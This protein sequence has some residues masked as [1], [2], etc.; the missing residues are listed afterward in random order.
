MGDDKLEIPENITMKEPNKDE[1]L[2]VIDILEN[3]EFSYTFKYCS[4]KKNC[5]YYTYKIII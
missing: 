3:Y 2:R 4:T 1:F 5:F